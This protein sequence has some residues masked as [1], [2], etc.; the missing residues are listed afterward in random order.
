MIKSEITSKQIFWILT[1]VANGLTL[2]LAYTP[3]F[4]AA[5]Q[6]AWIS[7]LIATVIALVVT[8][9]SCKVSMLYPDQTLVQFCQTILG[10][11]L[12]KLV[13]ALYFLAWYSLTPIMTRQSSET[14]K[15]L[16]LPRTPLFIIVIPLVALTMYITYHGIQ[17]IARANE[18][19]GPVIYITVV[20]IIFLLLRGVHWRYIL[21]IYPSDGWMPLIDGSLT[22]AGFMGESIVLM[23]LVPLLKEPEKLISR[24]LM[25]ITIVGLALSVGAVI[26]TGVLSPYIASKLW[27]P[28]FEAAKFVSI[29]DFVQNLDAIIT[30]IWLSSAFLKIAVY[31][32]LL[33]YGTAQLFGLKNWRNTIWFVGP[34]TMGLALVPQNMVQVNVLYPTKVWIP[35]VLPIDMLTLPCLLWLVG[36][37]RQKAGPKKGG[38]KL[39]KSMSS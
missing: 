11:W 23:M 28:A 10:K 25:A 33:C 2:A 38:G 15:Q 4:K 3:V 37:L 9:L 18:M 19:V 34:L 24:G 5:H 16:L 26:I 27:Y 21:P 20:V 13:V 17:V 36:V 6:D 8:Y 12:G 7:I 14:V 39:K 31:F 30:V 22:P 32:Y 1:N 29:G 35:Y